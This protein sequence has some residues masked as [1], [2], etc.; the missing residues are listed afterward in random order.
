ML[1]E[2]C[3][4]RQA[5]VHITQIVNGQKQEQ[6]LCEECAKEMDMTV[7]A[8]NPHVFT[9]QDFLK[10]MFQAPSHETPRTSR[11]CPECGMTYQD[12]SRTG[13]IGCGSCYKTFAAELEPVIRRI[14]GTSAHTGKVPRRSGEVLGVQQKLKRLKQSLERA[15]AREEYEDAA[16]FRDEIRR[17]EKESG[18]PKEEKAE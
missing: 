4:K 3:Q 18:T 6:H 5:C 12:F 7:L 10:G 14:H 8:V 11:A 9:I 13:K 16:K 1:C 17:L 15:V 2:R